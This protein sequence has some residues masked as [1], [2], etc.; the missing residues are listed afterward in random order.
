MTKRVEIITTF[1]GYPSGTD[2]SRTTYTAGTVV[3]LEDEFADLIIGKE[4]AKAARVDRAP[5]TASLGDLH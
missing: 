5:A 3:E 1:D 2:E 4:L